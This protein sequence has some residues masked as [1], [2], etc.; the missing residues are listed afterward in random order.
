MDAEC[1]TGHVNALAQSA[2]GTTDPAMHST[3]KEGRGLLHHAYA[4][5]LRSP[6]RRGSKVTSGLRSTQATVASGV[7]GGRRRPGGTSADLARWYCAVIGMPYPR[8]ASWT[9]SRLTGQ[10]TAQERNSPALGDHSAQPWGKSGS[11][12]PPRPVGGVNGRCR[13]TGRYEPYM[14]TT[15]AAKAIGVGKSTLQ[16]WAASGLVVPAL[17]TP[18][19]RRGGTSGT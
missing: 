11:V 6:G 15:I 4:R 9:I 17:R 19:G 18:G 8:A 10:V 7:H 13:R 3:A 12:R 14:T 16:R 2:L 1:K 5:A